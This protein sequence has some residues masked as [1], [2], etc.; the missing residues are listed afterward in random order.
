MRQYQQ[1]KIF[2]QIMYSYI[3][4]FIIFAVSVLIIRENLHLLQKYLRMNEVRD[5]A[6]LNLEKSIDTNTKANN[7]LQL[8][9]SDRGVEGYIRQAYPVIK[10]GENVITLYNASTSN[11][12]N[13][14]IEE[15]K[16]QKFII[17]WNQ[18]Y[19]NA[20]MDYT[21]LQK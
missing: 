16:W 10:S 4:I 11:I 15:S 14:N 20:I 21:K 5:K 13:I 2:N 17:W 6:S 12:L 8:I 18:I 7:K 3:S 9:N 1:A 19:N